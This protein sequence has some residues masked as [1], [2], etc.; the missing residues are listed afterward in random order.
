LMLNHLTQLKMSKP[1]FKTR[2]ES[3]PINRGWSLQESNSK[4]AGPLQITTSKRRP[5]FTWSSG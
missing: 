5:H 4:T 2:K 1:R 3:H